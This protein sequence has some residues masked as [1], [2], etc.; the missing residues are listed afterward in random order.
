MSD[1][2]IRDC[3]N[4]KGSGTCE[5]T[6]SLNPLLLYAKL[7]P[8][9]TLVIYFGASKWDGP[10]SIHEM[11]STQNEQLLRFVPEYRINLLAPAQISKED[12]SK[13]KTDFGKVLAYIKYSRDKKARRLLEYQP[14]YTCL[15][16]IDKPLI[17]RSRAISTEG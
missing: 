15:E 14:K 5:I 1:K 3:F 16:T 13:F 8:V 4:E 2:A 7:M 9:I 10:M 12:F 6:S 11:L 17:W